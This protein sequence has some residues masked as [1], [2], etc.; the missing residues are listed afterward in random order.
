M[1]ASQGA[2]PSD[3]SPELCGKWEA[4]RAFFK[5]D[6]AVFWGNRNRTL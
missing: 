2:A 1:T 4:L 5:A 6:L 3:S